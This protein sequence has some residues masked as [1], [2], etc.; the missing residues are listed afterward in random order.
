MEQVTLPYN[1]GNLQVIL[2]QHRANHLQEYLA[3]VTG[4]HINLKTALL[5]R[6]GELDL[7]AQKP[8]S[9][10]LGVIPPQS[11]VA[12]YDLA[13]SMLQDTRATDVLLTPAQYQSYMLD[14]WPWSGCFRANKLQNT[15]AA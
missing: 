1:K 4:Y 13:L 6:L 12:S 15:A 7:T 2:E 5:K 14:Q 3:A 8:L 9:H 11:H 10:S